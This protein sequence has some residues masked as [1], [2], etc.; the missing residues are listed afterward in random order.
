MSSL[1]AKIKWRLSNKFGN[2]LLKRAD[3]NWKLPSGLNISITSLADWTIYNEIFVNG[4]YDPAIKIL[5]DNNTSPVIL[6]LG[7]NVGFFSL[8]VADYLLRKSTN[9]DFT[10][11]LI[12]GSPS[13]F[14]LLKG[15]MEAQKAL[16]G[17]T[18]M[19]CGL[20]G[21]K[22][23]SAH[24]YEF[25]YHGMT[26]LSPRKL[27]KK[28]EV[29]YVD[30][31]ELLRE[32]RQ[33]DLLKCDIEG[34]EEKFLDAYPDILAKTKTL[35]AEFH[36]RQC[37]VPHCERL[38]SDAGFRRALSMRFGESTETAVFVKK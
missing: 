20:V 10:M 12:E 26:G 9:P 19:V 37:D 28:V 33:I 16:N 29:S 27:S 17:K 4:E 15:R 14:A 18:H 24:L 13:T 25:G 21:E 23:G 22:S 6:D 35:V 2:T 38:L 8:R 7:A 30:L 1:F 36:P 11:F 31:S 32:V 3:L 34:A 5:T